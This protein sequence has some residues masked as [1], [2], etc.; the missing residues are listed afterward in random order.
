[1]EL[2]PFEQRAHVLKAEALEALE[3]PEEFA[4]RLKAA[5]PRPAKGKPR[6]Q[7]RISGPALDV[8]KTAAALKAARPPKSIGIAKNHADKKT[9][10]EITGDA[11]RIYM[12]Y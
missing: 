3:K 6:L 10:E 4:A 7:I 2:I 9:R 12:N 8:L 1:M 5:H 11:L